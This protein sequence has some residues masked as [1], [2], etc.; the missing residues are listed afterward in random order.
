M[1][2]EIE[3]DTQEALQKILMLMNAEMIHKMID[4]IRVEG[5]KEKRHLLYFTLSARKIQSV[6]RKYWV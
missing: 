6:W 3:H 2:K 1:Q 4:Q 5:L